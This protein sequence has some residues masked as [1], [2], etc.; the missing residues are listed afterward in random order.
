MTVLENL[1]DDE[2]YLWAILSDPSGLDLAEFAWYDASTP[3]G[4]WRA[5][6]F[7]WKWFRNI[8]PLQ[9]SQCARSVGKS[10]SIKLRAFAFPFLHP[11]QEMVITAP[12]GVHLDAITDLIET[13]F[14]N[15]RLGRQML[16]KGRMGIK[17]RPFHMSFSN[18]TRIMG[19][20]PQ[21]DGKGVKGVHPLWLEM[22]EAQ[23]Y[24]DPGW[25]EIT[26]TL[27]RGHEGAVWRAHGVTKG[28]RDYFYKFTQD[29]SGW[30]VH[31]WC[32]PGDTLVY[33]VEKPFPIK[34]IKVG[35]EVWTITEDG[36]LSSDRVTA[37]IP[38]GVQPTW[39]VTGKGGLDLTSTPNHPYLLLDRKGTKRTRRT[40][41]FE[42][43]EAQ[44]IR[45]GDVVICVS[46]LPGNT[47]GIPSPESVSA[48]LNDHSPVR[49]VPEWLWGAPPSLQL[50]FLHGYLMGDGS[51]SRQK[52]G[53][54]PWQVG[55]ASR[56]MAKELRALCHYL[57]LRTTA[58][59]EH[60]QPQ[61]NGPQYRFYVY[62]DMAW[63]RQI[64]LSYSQVRDGKMLEG[65]GK[66]F[67]ART[68]TT[69]RATGETTETYDI[70]VGNAHNFIAEGVVTHNTAMHRPTWSDAERQEKIDNYGS[71]DHPDY[72]RNVLGLHGDAT[73]PLFVLHRLMACVDS[74]EAS[75]YNQAEYQQYRINAE[76]LADRGGDIIAMLDFPAYHKMLTK[77]FWA[78]MDVGYTNSPSEILV[79]GEIKPKSGPTYLKLLTRIHLERISHGDQVAAI[80]HVINS[81]GLKAFSMDKTG[82][83][84]PL[85]Q[86]L[87]ERA[88]KIAPLIKGYNFS[89]KILVDIDKT[90]EIDEFRGDEIDDAGIMKN[91][92]EYASD[93]LRE[94]VDTE[95]LMLPW[96]KDLIGEFQGQTYVVIR[97]N[98]NLYGKREFSKGKFHALDAARMA[99]LGKVQVP[100]EELL[101]NRQDKF[102]PVVDVFFD[103]W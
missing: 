98:M 70:T 40:L 86:D 84:L 25:I 96:D 18:G 21:R 79:F 9:I 56:V 58:M 80:H 13:G 31:R 89:S 99:I 12:E 30:V 94:Y 15:S 69:S 87:Q 85:F 76:G 73:N 52:R 77:V 2:A 20:I 60:P 64:P 102:E 51:L 22:D 16:V 50:A 46:N 54:N 48:T 97:D 45:P 90:I 65:L 29:R 66:N 19:R 44:D 75:P 17:H 7:Q 71:R 23:D 61:G 62:A 72:R 103:S 101:A 42:W 32:L 53:Q 67:I 78:G 28:V 41:K 3:D 5:W 95:R 4:C 37:L 33:G 74:D 10:L 92:L 49:S 93:C 100:M 11:N 34:D 1:S 36:Q 6:P 57:G 59:N 43:V 24:P 81:Y 83:G 91:V 35:T 8:S 55:T 68:V 26:E 88:P 14:M 38:N 47:S 27:K 39:R 82:L 63:F